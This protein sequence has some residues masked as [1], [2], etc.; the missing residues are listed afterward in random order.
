MIL[1]LYWTGIICRE[2]SRPLITNFYASPCVLLRSFYTTTLIQRIADGFRA[3]Y[4]NTT[5]KKY[6]GAVQFLQHY[7]LK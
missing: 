6:N 2:N 1:F 5:F 4:S 7:P 3:L